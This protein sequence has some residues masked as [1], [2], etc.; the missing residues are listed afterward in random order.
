[1]ACCIN[2]P[3]FG[4]TRE[5]SA[6]SSK[7]D[8][9]RY[10]N[11]SIGLHFLL[12]GS[13]FVDSDVFLAALKSKNIACV[14]VLERQRDS[15]HTCT[16]HWL[17]NLQNVSHT[18]HLPRDQPLSRYSNGCSTS[19]RPNSPP[20]A[21]SKCAQENVLLWTVVSKVGILSW[22]KRFVIDTSFLQVCTWMLAKL[23]Q[24]V[25][26]LSSSFS[27]RLLHPV[28][29]FIPH[30][31]QTVPEPSLSTHLVFFYI[32]ILVFLF[33]F[34]LIWCVF[35]WLYFLYLLHLEML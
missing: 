11:A 33:I 8:L 10:T 15:P 31:H 6:L 5:Q 28:C 34:Y 4:T 18:L 20:N 29:L 1:M 9:R 19:A 27:S 16:T 13:F 14:V 32:N 7:L 24:T 3:E 12:P 22:L 35:V 21:W 23:D 25:E 30:S 2:A 26:V 17:I